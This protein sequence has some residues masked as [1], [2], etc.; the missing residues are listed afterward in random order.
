MFALMA[1]EAAEPRSP[2]EDAFPWAEFGAPRGSGGVL[3]LVVLAEL[4]LRLLPCLFPGAL[5][6]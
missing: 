5:T 4:S 6:V 2:C 3:G 1:L